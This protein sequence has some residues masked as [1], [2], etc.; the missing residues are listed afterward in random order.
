MQIMELLETNE[1]SF[2]KFSNL[3]KN[4]M[5]QNCIR[6]VTTNDVK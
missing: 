5:R 6:N 3:H 2:F 1:D 4:E